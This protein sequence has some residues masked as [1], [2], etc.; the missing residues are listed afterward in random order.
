[1]ARM[2]ARPTIP[3]RHARRRVDR[4]WRQGDT[5][6]MDRRPLRRAAALSIAALLALAGPASADSLLADGEVQSATVQGSV[7]RG[8]VPAG[9][10]VVVPVRFVLNCTTL[11]HADVGQTIALSWSG[12]GSVPLGGSV[13][14]VTPTT[15][16]PIPAEWGVD[17]QGCPDPVPS[18]AS[19]IDSI[20]TLRAP[21]KAATGYSFVIEWDRALDPPGNEDDIALGFALPSVEI[22]LDVIGN[23]APT[24]TFPV[25]RTRE[26]DTTGGWTADWSGVTATDPEDDPDPAPSCTPADGM[27]LDIGPTTI[28]CSATDGGGQTTTGSFVLTVVDTTAPVLTMPGDRTVTTTDPSGTTL[29]YD[30]PAVA[31]IVDPAP[32]VVC[33][34]ADGTPIPLGPTTVTCTA[35][36]S[37]RN[38]RSGSF[39]VTVEQVATHT[40]RAVW[41]EPVGAGGSIVANRG[42]S[43]PVKVQLFVD[44]VERTSGDA[45]LTVTPCGGGTTRTLDLAFGGGR[46]NLALVTASLAGPCY[47]VAASIDGLV[48]GSFGLEMRGSEASAKR[49][50][51]PLVRVRT[52]RR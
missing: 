11:R 34:P 41:L 18:K 16:G 39:V 29:D 23:A 13:V 5:T 50:T 21:T 45:D 3:V 12:G 42:R 7:Y 32:T 27:V 49:L 6:T 15:L 28:V 36:D 19:T 2:L 40:A 10:E 30:P 52:S 14:S 22:R 48:A 9:S 33:S 26:G 8:A 4:A 44:G 47:T 35:T 43:L 17:G 46:W 25:D 20:V 51:S 24:L 31:D 37:S 1:M 38:V